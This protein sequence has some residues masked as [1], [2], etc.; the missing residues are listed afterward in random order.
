MFVALWAGLLEFVVV[1]NTV[2]HWP[3]YM[4][5]FT[6]FY[7]AARVPLE[8]VYDSAR[9]TA[10]QAWSGVD[11]T[12]PRPFPYPPTFLFVL[13]PFG[14]LGVLPA[15]AAWIGLGLSAYCVAAWKLIGRAWPLILLSPTVLVGAITGQV[16]F[17]MGAA[18]MAG[19]IWLPKRP[20][21]AGVVF[22][23]AATIKP[24]VMVFVPFA[25]VFAGQWRALG[26]AVV[27]GTLFGLVSLAVHQ[28]L[29]LEWIAAV[30]G[31]NELITH[32]AW[33]A[34]ISATPV[35]FVKSLGVEN[36]YALGFVS[37][38]SAL[39]ALVIVFRAFRR[40]DPLQRYA[41]LAIGYLLVAPY[42]LWYELALLQPVAVV[43]MLDRRWM[44][45]GAGLLGFLLFPRALGVVALAI[46]SIRDS[47]SVPGRLESRHGC[48]RTVRKAY[49]QGRCGASDSE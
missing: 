28:G 8:V 26:A 5:D 48:Y 7:T 22:G 41:A 13:W 31:F 11:G 34:K 6:V 37:V 27:A 35:G 3:I 12:A 47:L 43:A 23:L 17:L 15:L 30:R 49:R 46:T 36:G 16:T 44:N 14:R 42:A 19:V 9:L 24:Q 32:E 38:V 29:W 39:A 2:G 20:L 33:P 4:T 10:A 45:R 21:L 1:R 40:D 18:L 25:L